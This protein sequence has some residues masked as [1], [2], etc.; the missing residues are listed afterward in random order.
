MEMAKMSQKRKKVNES[1]KKQKF[2][3]RKRAENSKK[4][5]HLAPDGALSNTHPCA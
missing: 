1:R 5:N 4:L 2:K 3:K